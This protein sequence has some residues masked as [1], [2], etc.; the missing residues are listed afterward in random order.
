[1]RI[2]IGFTELVVDTMIATPVVDARLPGQCEAGGQEGTQPGARLVRSMRPEAVNAR[3]HAQCGQVDEQCVPPNGCT[4]D[5][6]HQRQAVEG[7]RVEQGQL[8]DIAPNDWLQG[9]VHFSAHG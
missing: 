9:G 6:H 2:R 7:D 3:L 1:M 8:D 5:A 4:L